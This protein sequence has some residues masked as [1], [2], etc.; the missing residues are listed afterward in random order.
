MKM[1]QA[2]NG[3]RPVVDDDEIYYNVTVSSFCLFCEMYVI[4]TK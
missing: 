3:L 4:D 1:E 2:W